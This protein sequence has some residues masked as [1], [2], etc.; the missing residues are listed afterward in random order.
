MSKPTLRADTVKLRGGR[1]SLRRC[2]ST[3]APPELDRSLPL[4]R[5]SPPRGRI[6]CRIRDAGFTKAFNTLRAF[7][8]SAAMDTA[9]GTR[10]GERQYERHAASPPNHL[11]L[12]ETG[13]R[14][15]HFEF[16]SNSEFDRATDGAKEFRT[17][18]GKRI[19]FER[20]HGDLA[21]LH[22]RAEDRGLAQQSEITPEYIIG[23]HGRI[24]ARHVA[25]GHA[26]MVARQIIHRQSENRHRPHV[27]EPQRANKAAQSH[28]FRAFPNKARAD[29]HRIY[30]AAAAREHPEQHR[31]V[32]AA[33]RKDRDAFRKR[34]YSIIECRR[35]TCFCSH[36]RARQTVQ[37]SRRPPSTIKVAPVVKSAPSHR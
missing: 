20:R 17:R 15:R 8:A 14:S 29:V 16:D 32:E 22:A 9:L 3:P 2:S 36:R 28:H 6:D 24:V 33:A 26:P 12:A 10:A 31:T 25:P 37:L 7:R 11:G 30:F 21:N 34:L 1:M 27:V 19:A 4:C 35:G 13:K 23:C 18:V 5:F